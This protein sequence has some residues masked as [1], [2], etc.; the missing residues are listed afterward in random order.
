MPGM[1]FEYRGDILVYL[2]ISE[3]ILQALAGYC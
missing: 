3:Y 2:E 1:Y